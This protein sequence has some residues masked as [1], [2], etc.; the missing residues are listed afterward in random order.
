LLAPV[1]NTEVGW[2]VVRS[3]TTRLLLVG[4][5]AARIVRAASYEHEDAGDPIL[6]TAR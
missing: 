5:R 6:V 4:L 3:F 1:T 2:W